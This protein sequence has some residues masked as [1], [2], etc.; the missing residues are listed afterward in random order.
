[1]A[2]PRW[3]NVHQKENHVP[4]HH[5]AIPSQKRKRIFPGPPLFAPAAAPAARGASAPQRP[6]GLRSSPPW[7]AAP[8]VAGAAA[9]ARPA[10]SGCRGR[11]RWWRSWS[12]WRWAGPVGR[13]SPLE[14]ARSCYEFNEWCLKIL[15]TNSIMILWRLCLKLKN[16]KRRSLGVTGKTSVVSRKGGKIRCRSTWKC[17]SNNL[18]G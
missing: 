12:W 18:N 5:P 4:N 6:P 2:I 14:I 16:K 9:V 3:K 15:E 1:M 7:A 10:A 17:T 11:R 13:P 8:A